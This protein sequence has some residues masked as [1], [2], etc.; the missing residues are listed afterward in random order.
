MGRTIGNPFITSSVYSSTLATMNSRT[1]THHVALRG[2]I[3]GFEYLLRYSHSNNYGRYY[4]VNKTKN[5]AVYCSVQKLVPQAWN[6]NFGVAF[7]ADIGTQFGNSFGAMFTI[8]RR[9]MIW[10]SKK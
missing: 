8:S 2:D 4:A 3:Y 10:K 9:G 7:G 5:N 6:L 1:F